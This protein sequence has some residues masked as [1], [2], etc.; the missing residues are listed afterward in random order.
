MKQ[1]LCMMLQCHLMDYIVIIREK[2]T[3]TMEK[4]DGHLLNQ[5]IKYSIGN[6]VQPDSITLL[7]MRYLREYNIAC[8]LFTPKHVELE[9]HQALDLNSSSE[10][11]RRKIQTSPEHGKIYK[12]ALLNSSKSRYHEK[13]IFRNCFQTHP[14]ELPAIMKLQPGVH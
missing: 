11:P 1:D 13:K 2:H 8:V 9:F 3:L 12:T 5:V 10:T 6:I 7:M 14:I 4:S